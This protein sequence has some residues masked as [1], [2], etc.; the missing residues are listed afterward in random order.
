MGSLSR[1]TESDT[2]EFL[3]LLLL[4]NG[5]LWICLVRAPLH[6]CYEVLQTGGGGAPAARGEVQLGPGDGDQCAGVQGYQQGAD[7]C[8]ERGGV[9]GQNTNY[10]LLQVCCR[11]K[12][13]E[14]FW[15]YFLL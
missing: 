8:Q 14:R 15:W 4:H 12:V 13:N 9:H 1:E 10:F 11:N 5:L 6:D 3:L 7:Q 2:Q